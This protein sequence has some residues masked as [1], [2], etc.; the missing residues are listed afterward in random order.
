M[1]L[2][3]LLSDG[4]MPRRTT[5]ARRAVDLTFITLIDAGYAS[6]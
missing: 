4:V 1:P 3:D 5:S 6:A 2:E